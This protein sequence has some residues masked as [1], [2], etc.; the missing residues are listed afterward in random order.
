MWLIDAGYDLDAL[1]DKLV[2][3]TTEHGVTVTEV[4]QPEHSK[5]N[6]FLAAKPKVKR[7]V[8]VGQKRPRESSSEDAEDLYDKI[9]TSLFTIAHF[10]SKYF[11]SK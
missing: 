9:D 2:E 8:E 3:V 10:N 6:P 4:A 1:Q 7:P 11:F 5:A